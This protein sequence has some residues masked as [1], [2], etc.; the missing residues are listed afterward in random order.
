MRTRQKGRKSKDKKMGDVLELDTVEEFEDGRDGGDR[1]VAVV[2]AMD[3][4][5]SDL[6]DK[7]EKSSILSNETGHGLQIERFK[8]FGLVKGFT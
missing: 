2:K 5:M 7:G 6:K 3:D 8:L 1:E 4:G